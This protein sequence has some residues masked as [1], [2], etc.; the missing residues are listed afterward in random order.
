MSA[1]R[2]YP[3]PEQTAYHAAN[4]NGHSP[5][6]RSTAFDAP[7]QMRTF[8]AY[9]HAVT[10]S[11]DG[12]GRGLSASLNSAGQFNGALASGTS[13]HPS[14]AVT[15]MSYGNGQSFTQTLNAR[16]LP[17]RMTTIGAGTGPS[18]T[19]LDLTYSYTARGLV[20]DMT[21]GVNFNNSRAY[22]YDGQGRLTSATGPWGETGEIDL[23]QYSYDSLGNLRSKILGPRHVALSYNNNNRLIAAN[24]SLTETHGGTG[25]R[26]VSYDSRGNIKRLGGQS[27][28]YNGMN[29][30][31]GMSGD[32]DGAYRY[33]GH[34]RRVKSVTQK[35]TGK[36]T[37]YS[38]Y[39]ST[40]E[41]IYIV[42]IDQTGA[43]DHYVTTQVTL[44]T[45]SGSGAGGQTLAR[46]KSKGTG[47]PNTYA[48]EV[49][50]LHNDHLG[51]AGSGT[52]AAG[53]VMWREEYSPF[54]LTMKND[55][56]NDNQAGFTGHIKD[57]DTGLTYMQARYYDPV[58]G[59]FLSIDPVDFMQSGYNPAYFNRY[60]Y[61]GN[62]PINNIDPDG[63]FFGAAGKLV[64][65]AIKG[66]DIGA[67]FAGAV[68]DAKTLTGKNVS[69][70]RRLGAA[71]SLATE[72]FSPV[73]ARDAKA[74]EAD[75]M[76][77]YE[78]GYVQTLIDR[79]VNMQAAKI[80]QQTG[81]T[82]RAL[83]AY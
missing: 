50:Y 48:D 45:G 41:L 35:E 70:G 77:S 22:E 66:G 24:D 6:S 83:V 12:L 37:R 23:A 17:D 76:I 82:Y 16:L 34:G 71:A 13:Y 25:N 57:S 55:A 2:A 18:E 72:V 60:A 8:R 44:D 80:A 78:R 63:Q 79:E 31:T 64:K 11:R 47:T 58:I 81:K 1:V 4:D 68:A 51:S 33:D 19:A 65:L 3:I 56:A 49:T 29:R 61:S 10:Y 38:V 53:A 15:A 46:V 39:G 67:T 69:L 36:V 30:P 40:G 52:D 14:G 26:T 73:S 59:R 7:R 74:G 42:Q 43:K 28:R 20:S 9:N 5:N 32:V 62:D 21:D 54:G 75:K 27:F